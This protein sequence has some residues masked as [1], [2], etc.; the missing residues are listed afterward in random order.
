MSTETVST[1]RFDVVVDSLSLL[2]L[3]STEIVTILHVD[4]VVDNPS[5][6]LLR[7]FPLHP[8]FSTALAFSLPLFDA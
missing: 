6:L 8:I 7:H 2:L 5:L 1:L 3:R 4:L